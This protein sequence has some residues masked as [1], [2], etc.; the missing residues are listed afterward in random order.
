LAP[1]WDRPQD[2]TLLGHF[3]PS[4]VWFSV[5]NRYDHC[6]RQFERLNNLAQG[7]AIHPGKADLRTMSAETL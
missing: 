6:R 5:D 2:W 1:F 3:G 7:F 4:L